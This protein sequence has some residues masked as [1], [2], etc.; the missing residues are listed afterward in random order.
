MSPMLP[1]TTTTVHH[2]RPSTS[3]VPTPAQTSRSAIRRLATSRIA[4]RTACALSI[5]KTF[6]SGM[7]PHR[8]ATI[9]MP[10]LTAMVGCATSTMTAAWAVAH[11]THP[12]TFRSGTDGFDMM[13]LGVEGCCYLLI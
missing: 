10:R 3:E 7:D 5:T 9:P 11:P 12:P 13:N 6:R 2:H 1:I 8:C 4:T